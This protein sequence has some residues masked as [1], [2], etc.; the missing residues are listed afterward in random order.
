MNGEK[1]KIMIKASEINL[2]SILPLLVM[3]NALSSL[4]MI[5]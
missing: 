2:L 1:P 5:Y 4:V 3:I